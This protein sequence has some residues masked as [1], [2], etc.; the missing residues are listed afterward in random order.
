MLYLYHGVVCSV[1]KLY[2]FLNCYVD[3]QNYFKKKI[4]YNICWK[5]A[6]TKT[7]WW[8]LVRDRTRRYFRWRFS[9]RYILFILLVVNSVMLGRKRDD[10]KCPFNQDS[11]LWDLLYHTSIRLTAHP[12]EQII[13]NLTESI[14]G[15]YLKSFL[16]SILLFINEALE[17]NYNYLLLLK[18]NSSIKQ[19]FFKLTLKMISILFVPRKKD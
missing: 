11:D 3:T 2:T 15:S 4:N 14:S 6:C 19:Y 13:C 1:Q 17:K 18:S 12:M 7:C 9:F 16:D 5:D 10:N 8:L